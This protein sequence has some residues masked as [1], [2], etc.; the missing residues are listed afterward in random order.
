[1]KLQCL[2]HGKVDL[3]FYDKRCHKII[4]LYCI[5]NKNSQHFGH[6]ISTLRSICKRHPNQ[7]LSK[8]CKN[9][10]DFICDDCVHHNGHIMKSLPWKNTK[11]YSQDKLHEY[12]LYGLA[13]FFDRVGVDPKFNFEDEGEEISENEFTPITKYKSFLDWN[14]TSTKSKRRLQF[15]KVNINLFI[16]VEA[17]EPLQP[18]NEY[19]KYLIFDNYKFHNSTCYTSSYVTEVFEIDNYIEKSMN[20]YFSDNIYDQLTGKEYLLNRITLNINP[21]LPCLYLGLVCRF[22]G[23]FKEA[24]QYFRDALHLYNIKEAGYCLYAMLKYN[25]PIIESPYKCH[26]EPLEIAALLQSPYCQMLCGDYYFK[27]SKEHGQNLYKKSFEYHY[28]AAKLGSRQCQFR[29][30]LYYLY[31]LFVKVDKEEAFHWF[32]QAANQNQI[33]SYYQLARILFE[34]NSNNLSKSYR[35]LISYEWYVR[36]ALYGNNHYAIE[37]LNTLFSNGYNIIKPGSPIS[38]PTT[39]YKG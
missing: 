2:V 5:E 17:S 7:Q 3:L 12:Y 23:K 16:P 4:C 31:G 26:I 24:F 9:C 37:H 19:S 15:D 35:Y 27:Q 13:R 38:M 6:S 39:S 36:A 30:G 20:Y 10:H 29:I 28:Q 34:S 32:Y 1:M 21:G 18:I 11:H 14:P 25:D 8:F 22:E 33:D